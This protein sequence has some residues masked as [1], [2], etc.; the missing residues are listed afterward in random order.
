MQEGKSCGERNDVAKAGHE[1]EA[2]CHCA[3][4][5][6]FKDEGTARRHQKGCCSAGTCD[7]GGHRLPPEMEAAAEV[8]WKEFEAGSCIASD[9]S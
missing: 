9:A 5:R 2:M 1:A 3:C 6:K 8:K 7:D 4:G